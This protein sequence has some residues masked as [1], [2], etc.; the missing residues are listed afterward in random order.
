MD[1]GILNDVPGLWPM[2][3]DGLPVKIPQTSR[4]ARPVDFNVFVQFLE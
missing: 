4:S 1:D 3:D 2:G